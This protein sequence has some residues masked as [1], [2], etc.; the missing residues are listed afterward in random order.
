MSQQLSNVDLDFDMPRSLDWPEG[1]R[2]GPDVNVSSFVLHPPAT[3]PVLDRSTIGHPEPCNGPGVAWSTPPPPGSSFALG[4]PKPHPAYKGAALASPPLAP[5]P[6]FDNN[7]QQLSTPPQLAATVLP[8]TTNWPLHAIDA[9]TFLVYEPASDVG[10][11][12]MNSGAMTV[13]RTSRCWGK[14]WGDCV[15]AFLAFLM[16]AAFP[17]SYLVVHQISRT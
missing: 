10:N 17:V 6:G 4:R 12:G 13:A 3:P 1:R 16:D 11:L 14:E 15:N 5:P 7:A 8:D 9:A 2:D